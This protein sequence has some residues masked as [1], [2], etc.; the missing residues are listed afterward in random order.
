MK[1]FKNKVALI[2]GAASGMGRYLAINLAKE[3]ADVVICDVD[4]SGLKETEKLIKAYNVGSSSLLL[5]VRDKKEVEEL[6]TKIIENHGKIDLVFN[7]AGVVIPTGFLNMNEEDWN[8]CNDINY[9]SIIN[10]SRSFLPHLMKEEETAL[11]NTSSIFGII[12]TPNNTVYHASKFAVRGFTESLAKEMEGSNTQIHCVYPGHIGTNIAVN[13]K[14]GDQ[15]V[16]GENKEGILGLNGEPVKDIKG[17]QVSEKEAG[18][19][20]RDAG[21]DPDKAA[22]IILK[23]IKKNKKRIFVGIDAKLME[24]SQRIFPDSYWRMMP[25]TLLFGLLLSPHRLKKAFQ[26][27]RK[28][29]D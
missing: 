8:W 3:G 13:A 5:D 12:T 23:G 19:R 11:I 10:F 21:M 20:F 2:T 18:I 9:N 15:V 25:I 16:K 28:K 1:T 17:N 6:P 24:I 4:E 26:L 7:N 22:K 14:F 29:K 27:T